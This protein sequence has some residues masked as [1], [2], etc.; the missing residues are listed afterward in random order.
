MK[1]LHTIFLNNNELRDEG[2]KNFALM[3]EN[4]NLKILIQDKINFNKMEFNFFYK[5]FK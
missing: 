5:K 1:K 4:S 2:L 3:L